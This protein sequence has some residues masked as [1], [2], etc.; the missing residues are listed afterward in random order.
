MSVRYPFGALS[1]QDG[2]PP[3]SVSALMYGPGRAITY[4][5][6]CWAMFRN[7]FMSRTPPKSYTPGDGEV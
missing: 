6:A 7:S 3:P 2:M 4:R 5:P 1:T